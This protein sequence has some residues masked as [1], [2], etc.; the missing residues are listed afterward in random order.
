MFIVLIDY[1][2]V[3][4]W[5]ANS[6]YIYIYIYVYISRK[7]VSLWKRITKHRIDHD[8]TINNCFWHWFGALPVPWGWWS[9]DVHVHVYTKFRWLFLDFYNNATRFF[10]FFFISETS[11]ISGFS[12]SRISF[13]IENRV[14]NNFWKNCATAGEIVK[15]NRRIEKP[16]V[17]ICTQGVS[18]ARWNAMDTQIRHTV[19]SSLIKLVRVETCTISLCIFNWIYR[20][21][22]L[23]FPFTLPSS[24]TLAF[25][26]YI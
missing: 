19:L 23:S 11:V 10:V 24:D 22:F 21:R 3:N 12:R 20:H 18:R 2:F 15:K 4:L 13:S 26:I 1:S 6:I 7:F 14:K 5:I 8:C 25:Y 17:E 16:K 9:N